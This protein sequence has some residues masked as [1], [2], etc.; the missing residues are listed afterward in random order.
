M[1]EIILLTGIPTCGKSTFS[2]NEKYKDYVRI[3]SDD[4]IENILSNSSKSYLS[5]LEENIFYAEDLMKKNFLEAI[6]NEK[7]I[8]VDRLN[9]SREERSEYLSVVPS[10]YKKIAV[11]F[12]I[13]LDTALK[14][15]LQRGEKIIPERIIKYT[16]D[17]YQIPSYDEGFDEIM[18][19]SFL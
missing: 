16:F 7:N 5:I 13:S 10:T 8:I 9:I 19:Y 1:N 4:Y 18:F 14:R 2:K 3:S 6:K 11:S 12:E 15:N 17:N